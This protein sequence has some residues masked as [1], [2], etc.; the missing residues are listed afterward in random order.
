MGDKALTVLIWS[1]NEPSRLWLPAHC[2]LSSF[3]ASLAGPL[4]GSY[5]C[6]AA[7]R[8][9]TTTISGK[10]VS[11]PDTGECLICPCP[12]VSLSWGGFCQPVLGKSCPMERNQW[13]YPVYSEN[14]T[15]SS[16]RSMGKRKCLPC[17]LQCKDEVGNN[18][19]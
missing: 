16:L 15:Q 3:L 12:A 6:A 18:A 8:G 11:R 9:G 4:P 19:L 2:V 13:V 7:W 5:L 10:V 14:R 1:A 17:S